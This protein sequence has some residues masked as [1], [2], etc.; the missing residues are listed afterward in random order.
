MISESI[1][2]EVGEVLWTSAS[3]RPKSHRHQK[4]H[5]DKV[6]QG[7]GVVVTS[8]PPSSSMDRQQSYHH[9][10]S[11]HQSIDHESTILLSP[12]AAVQSLPNSEE[13]EDNKTK[14]T[15]LTLATTPTTAVRKGSVFTVDTEAER[16]GEDNLLHHPG[17]LSPMSPPST[18]RGKLNKPN[19]ETAGGMETDL[20]YYT[21]HHSTCN[22]HHLHHRIIEFSDTND[23][24]RIEVGG[25]GGK[26]PVASTPSQESY[27]IQ[28]DI[29]RGKRF[30]S[31]ELILGLDY[32]NTHS[33]AHH[34]VIENSLNN[35]IGYDLNGTYNVSS[36]ELRRNKTTTTSGAASLPLLHPTILRVEITLNG[37]DWICIRTEWKGRSIIV[38]PNNPRARA[39]RLRPLCTN[40]PATHQWRFHGFKVFGTKYMDS[41][42]VRCVVEGTESV[43][44]SH[45]AQISVTSGGDR[46]SLY[47]TSDMS[48]LSPKS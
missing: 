19:F 35:W 34:V 31:K 40:N 25:N 45:V 39:I 24:P 5:Y 17:V 20:E 2:V 16:E 11:H 44:S 47:A 33:S 42:S 18:N 46:G 14:T 13:E 26:R 22:R 28:H 3:P 15:S 30:I 29:A 10:H 6:F 37:R 7:E 12:P 36:I 38:L 41:R 9:R 8:P 32:N 23:S 1:E 4:H 21:H 43:N 27:T 48:L